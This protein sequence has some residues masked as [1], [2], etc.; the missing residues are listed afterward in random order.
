MG[1][2]KF[3]KAG[4]EYDLLPADGIISV[5]S[6]GQT[7]CVIS[8]SG[9]NDSDKV[10]KATL[11][12]TNTVGGIG[13]GTEVRLRVNNAIAKATANPD[14]PPTLVNLLSSTGAGNEVLT[15]TTMSIATI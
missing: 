7:N 5:T 11:V 15:S 6:S 9:F 3:M 14:G 12:I 2:L 4:T 1:Y 8:Y 10:L 13:S